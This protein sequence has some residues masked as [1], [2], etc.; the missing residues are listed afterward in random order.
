MFAQSCTK[1]ENFLSNEYITFDNKYEQG[2][3]V[4]L[5]GT[6]PK[7]L[8]DNYNRYN[9][10]GPL[11]NY[12]GPFNKTT[13]IRCKNMCLG[14][15]ECNPIRGNTCKP[16]YNY[17]NKSCI[18][19][20]RKKTNTTLNPTAILLDEINKILPN[21]A[22]P[23]WTYSLT[24]NNYKEFVRNTKIMW[25]DLKIRNNNQMSISFWIYSEKL[26]TGKAIKL[27][28][29]KMTP[30]RT[31]R[32]S[33]IDGN[34]EIRNTYITNNTNMN[35]PITI[36]IGNTVD[37]STWI[38]ISYNNSSQSVFVNGELKEGATSFGGGLYATS[39]TNNSLKLFN[40]TKYNTKGVFVKDLKIYDQSIPERVIS[41]LYQGLI[42]GV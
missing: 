19:S 7:T 41:I 5:N 24:Q 3:Y 37:S 29:F 33:I 31:I 18:C 36:P 25:P 35:S 2:L 14:Q 22:K 34:L 21:D 4:N 16:K 39:D 26:N 6:Y 40:D 10:S 28:A 32:F 11:F 12:N 9:K 1:K 38:M 23:S 15:D 8:T 42:D 27:M 13:K 17:K 30:Y 20:F